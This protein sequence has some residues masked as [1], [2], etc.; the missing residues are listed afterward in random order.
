LGARA[1]SLCAALVACA[2]PAQ[3]QQP[4]FAAPNL[5]ESGIRDMAAN[6]APCHGTRGR[7][8]PGSTVKELAGRTDVA[9]LLR[10]FREGKREST[11]MQQ[12]ARGYGD[13]EIE[14]I[15]AYFARQPR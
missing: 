13:A 12:I 5:T 3:G 6:C 7:A 1:A 9:A 14:A 8:A 10:A 11:V 15:G 4:A 2:I